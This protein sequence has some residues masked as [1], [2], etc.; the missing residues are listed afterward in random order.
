MK[1]SEQ[2]APTKASARGGHQPAGGLSA[3]ADAS[4]WLVSFDRID[5]GLIGRTNERFTNLSQA[6]V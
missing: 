4:A 5:K 2:G 6:L 3:E 1:C